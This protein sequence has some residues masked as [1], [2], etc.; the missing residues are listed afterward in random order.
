M[1]FFAAIFL[2]LFFVSI[3]YWS[4]V[5]TAIVGAVMFA[6]IIFFQR[7]MYEQEYISTESCSA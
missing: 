2:P 5:M 6:G 3:I 4:G 1:S 7:N